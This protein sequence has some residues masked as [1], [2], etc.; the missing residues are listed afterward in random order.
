[1]LELSNLESWT[2]IDDKTIHRPN[3]PRLLFCFGILGF[4]EWK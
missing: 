3:V 1:M 2:R 4:L